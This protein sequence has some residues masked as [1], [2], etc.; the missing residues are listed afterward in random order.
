MFFK[1]LEN[2]YLKTCYSSQ[3]KQNSYF[4]TMAKRKKPQKDPEELSTENEL[5][6]L[7]MMAEL[8]GNFL[9]SDEL[10]PDIE[11]KFLKQIMRFHKKHDTSKRTTLYKLIG[12][13][14]YN[15]VND[16]SE[17][18]LDKELSKIWNIMNKNGIGLSVLYDVPKREIYRFITEE[19]FK[20][21]VDDVKMKGWTN[22]Y[23]YEE[24]HPTE[25][26]DLKVAVQQCVHMIFTHDIP[27]FGEQFSEELKDSIGLSMEPE[28]LLEKIEKFQEEFLQLNLHE[29]TMTVNSKNEEAKTAHVTCEANYRTQKEKGQRFK[30][31]VAVLEFELEKA[32]DVLT[33]WNIKQIITDLF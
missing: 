13:P 26:Y 8:G 23:I 33:F 4:Q 12:S 25:D 11:N 14:E 28:D 21:E 27:F 1:L 2:N 24:F 3:K 19:L 7:K 31:E 10:P 22:Q 5:L 20:L 18:Q 9:G 29:I 32:D 16:I 15:H 6:K 30:K 17:K